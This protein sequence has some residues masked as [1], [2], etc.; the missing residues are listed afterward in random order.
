MLFILCLV[1][2]FAEISFLICHLRI[3]ILTSLGWIFESCQE[4]RSPW[5]PWPTSFDAYSQRYYCYFKETLWPKWIQKIDPQCISHVL[6]PHNKLNSTY[7][8]ILFNLISPIHHRQSS[9]W[10]LGNGKCAKLFT[11]LILKKQFSSKKFS[12]AVIVKKVRTVFFT[13][14]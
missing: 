5:F 10:C 12:L 1:S 11:V 2:I 14:N 8:I 13:C 3:S 6:C 9:R 7:I 4:T